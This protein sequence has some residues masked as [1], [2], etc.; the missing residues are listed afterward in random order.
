MSSR[1]IAKK[2]RRAVEFFTTAKKDMARLIANGE[3]LVRGA[4]PPSAEDQIAQQNV[5]VNR[6]LT[7]CG[8]TKPLSSRHLSLAHR[9]V[10]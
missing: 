1:S 2:M 8:F 3:F 5:G 6:Y 10:V 7:S 9:R 4:T